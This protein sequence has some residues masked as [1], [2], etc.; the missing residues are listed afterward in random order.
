MLHPG[1]FYISV[2]CLPKDVKIPGVESPLLGRRSAAIPYPATGLIVHCIG[3][4]S[5]QCI[6]MAISRGIQLVRELMYRSQEGGEAVI[7]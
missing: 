1:D 3:K 5:G 7:S 4:E 6:E 2:D